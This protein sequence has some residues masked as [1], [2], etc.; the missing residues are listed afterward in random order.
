MS[1]SPIGGAGKEDLLR[2]GAHCIQFYNLLQKCCG[3]VVEQLGSK[4]RVDSLSNNDV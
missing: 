2:K 1:A 3:A 4:L